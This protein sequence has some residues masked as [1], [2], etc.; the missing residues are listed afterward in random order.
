M[1]LLFNQAQLSSKDPLK[2]NSDDATA[3][4]K[5][6]LH[7]RGEQRRKGKEERNSISEVSRGGTGRKERAAGSRE[8]ST[9]AREQQALQGELGLEA[10]T[11]GDNGAGG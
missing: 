1:H 10:E 8:K 11:Q 4:T 9:S 5:K 2:G 7:L 6:E 3:T